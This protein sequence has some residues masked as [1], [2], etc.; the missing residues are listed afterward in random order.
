[1]P[2]SRGAA[3]ARTADCGEVDLL[4]AD[5]GNAGL[6]IEMTPVRSFRVWNC[7]GARAEVIWDCQSRTPSS[8]RKA[9]LLFFGCWRAFRFLDRQMAARFQGEADQA[10]QGE[11]GWST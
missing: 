3:L 6:D 7:A 9:S 10:R 1:M 5:A 4:R 8:R 11:Q 2:L